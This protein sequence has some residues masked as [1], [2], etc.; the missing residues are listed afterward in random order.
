MTFHGRKMKTSKFETFLT[1]FGA[2]VLAILTV[3]LVACLGA[4]PTKWIVNWLFTSDVLQGV[5]GG[6][7]TFWTALGLNFLCSWLFKG[8]TSK[9]SS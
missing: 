3:G 7:L 1:I 9:S 2:T 5:F 4:Y 6:P 8:T